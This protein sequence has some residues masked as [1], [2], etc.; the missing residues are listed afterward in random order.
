MSRSKVMVAHHL[1]SAKAFSFGA[2]VLLWLGLVVG[3]IVQLGF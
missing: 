3:G 1:D 2:I